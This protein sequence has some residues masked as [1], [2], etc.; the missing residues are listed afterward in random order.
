MAEKLRVA[1]LAL[2]AL[3]A[4]APAAGE[5]T[6]E[7]IARRAYEVYGGDDAFSRLH[8]S[9]EAEGRKASRLTVVMG[10]KRGGGDGVDYRVIMFNEHPPDTRDVGF[11]G[12][13]YREDTGREAE[14]WLYLPELRVSRRLT[15]HSHEHHGHAGHGPAEDAVDEF[16]VSELDH[17]E[18]MPRWPDLDDHRLLGVEE[19]EGGAAYVLESVPRDPHSSAYA[20]RVQ[21]IG[22]DEP[23]PRR[24]EYY[25]EDGSLVKTQTLEWRRLDEAWVW[26]RVVAVNHLTGARTVLEQ[27][28]VRINAGLP[29]SLFARRALSLGASTFAGRAA[30]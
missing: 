11:L 20:R 19:I 1:V 8:F 12:T 27:T 7:E 2:L 24:I 9:F 28:D 21:W 16:S 4:A 29:D 3:L 15:T 25:D 26:G 18:L 5:P 30:R 13:F 6:A 22:R 23:L 14:M 17:E 10:F